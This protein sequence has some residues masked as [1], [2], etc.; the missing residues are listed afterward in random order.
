MSTVIVSFPPAAGG[1]HLKNIISLGYLKNSNVENVYQ[2]D[3][4]VA[5]NSAWHASLGH[6]LV[7]EQVQLAA[8]QPND[9]H[10][11]HGHFGEILTY[12]NIIR[13]IADKKFVLISPDSPEQ[14]AML[15]R[16]RRQLEYPYFADGDYFD[17]EQ[18]FLYEHTTYCHYFDMPSDAIMNV[19]VDELF[20]KDIRPVL[21]RINYFLS[22]NI[23][24]AQVAPLHQHWISKNSA[25]IGLV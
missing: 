11:L 14:R 13:S 18:V 4:I 15:N 10:I 12:Q 16:R 3:S 17:G 19:S 23:D 24:Y 9:R 2:S 7:A 6:N 8:A 21:D 22:I 5:H 20:N 1:N 25:S